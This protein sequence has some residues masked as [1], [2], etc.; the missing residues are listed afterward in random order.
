MVWKWFIYVGLA[1][2]FVGLLLWVGTK[3]GVS[4]GKLPGDIQVHK[5]K[6]SFYFPIVV[7]I[8]LTIFI[9]LIFWFMRK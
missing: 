1:L 8:V 7:S 4:F 5:E 9:N 2:I 3:L 6:F